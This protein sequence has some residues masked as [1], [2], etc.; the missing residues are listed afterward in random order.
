MANH[1]SVCEIAGRSIPDTD[2]INERAVLT[3]ARDASGQ[4]DTPVTGAFWAAITAGA[5]WAATRI[6]ATWPLASAIQR[7]AMSKAVPWST[8]L[9]ITGRP[10]VQLTVRKK[11]TV[12][13]ATW[14]WS[15]YRE[16]TAS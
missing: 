9:R 15:W 7:P 12:L 5:S 3:Q 4:A 1:L 10:R 11:S 6:A 16:S 2:Q 13:A 8:E 14:P